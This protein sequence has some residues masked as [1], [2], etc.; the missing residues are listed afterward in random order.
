MSIVREQEESDIGEH[1][2]LRQEVECLKQ[3]EYP[4]LGVGR[5]VSGGVVGLCDGTE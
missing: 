1:E 4:F 2:V 5:E 3:L